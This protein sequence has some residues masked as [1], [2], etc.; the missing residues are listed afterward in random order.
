MISSRT[1]ED[2]AEAAAGSRC[3]GR[4]RRRVGLGRGPRRTAR[5]RGVVR[6]RDRGPLRLPRRP[7]QQRGHQ[8]LLRPHD[9]HR[10]GAGAEDL[11]GE[12]AL[13]PGLDGGRGEGGAAGLRRQCRL[14]RGARG[15]AEHRL[16]QRDQG[17]RPPHHAA[18]RVR[19]RPRGARERSGARPGQ[20]EARGGPVGRARARSGSPR[21]SRCADSGYPTTSPPPPCSWPRTQR[22]GSPARP[23]SSTEAPRCSPR[24][25]SAEP[26]AATCS[27]P[28]GV[29]CHT[30]SPVPSEWVGADG[31]VV[32][33]AHVPLDYEKKGI[34]PR[35]A[36]RYTKRRMG[37]MVEPTAAASHHSGVLVA[38]GCLE[39]A[40]QLGWKKLDPTLR[41]LAVQT[42]ASPDRVLVVHRLRLLRGHEPR[43]GPGQGPGSRR[44][45]ARAISS[46]IGSGRSSSTR[47]WRPRAR[48]RFRTRS[49][50]ASSVISAM[51]EF[52][53][54]A[55]WVALENFRSRF[56]AGLGL[57]S[58]GFSDSL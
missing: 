30:P 7:G 45:G 48:R 15:R 5:R 33:M 31:K 12:P 51:Q 38:M 23:S 25:A 1:E 8:S 53:E 3:C 34:V 22:R 10:P 43:H 29:S 18:A 35:L 56:N 55:A 37:Q 24:V 2:L 57:R 11:R 13:G 4:T 40:V 41:W 54:L 26:T 6:R 16:V 47:R 19:A 17:G 42:A 39:T 46:T 36:R 49:P 14:D 21:M 32:T 20:D 52:V 58:Q 28:G 9:R 50:P 44:N 27:R